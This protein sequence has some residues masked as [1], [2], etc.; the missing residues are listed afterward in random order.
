[1][2]KLIE[3]AKEI[4]SNL[5]PLKFNFDN[6]NSYY[7]G[8]S[9]EKKRGIGE[10][11]WEY[12]KFQLGD[13]V[14]NIDWKKTIKSKDIF[15]KFKEMETSK[16]VWIWMNTNLSMKYKNSPNHETKAER[17]SIIGI[18][19]IDIFIRAGES[20]GIIGSKLGL[21]NGKENFF[22]LVNVFLKCVK[23]P[24][25]KRIKKGD[26]IILISDFLEKPEKSIS[27]ITMISD[28]IKEG[29][30]IQTLDESEINF[31]FFGRNQFYD[32]LSGLHKLFN[33]SELIKKSYIK[34][35]KEH[36]RKLEILCSRFGWTVFRTVSN[37]SYNSFIKHLYNRF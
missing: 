16:K 11:F 36:N 23:D 9:K 3:K 33:K 24:K 35:V 10:E 2:N 17:A 14:R 1:M 8:Y 34:K 7:R 5:P 12:K 21:R 19:L 25:D 6:S 31:P 29:I 15:I 20:V 32:P 4:S 13:P 37:E 27:K 22:N 18:I 28:N 26:I 30:L